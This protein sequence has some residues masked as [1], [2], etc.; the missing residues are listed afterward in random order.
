MDGPNAADTNQSPVF[1]TLPDSLKVADV[2]MMSLETMQDAIERYRM[3]ANP[4]DLLITVPRDTAST[5]D[6][7]RAQDIADVGREK[8]IAAFD[9]VGL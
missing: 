7:H 2:I 5:Y 1:N 9:A 4:P 8:A 6:F 3:A